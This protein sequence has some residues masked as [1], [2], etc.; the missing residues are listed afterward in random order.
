MNAEFGGPKSIY[1]PP[2]YSSPT[3]YKMCLRLFLNGDSNTRGTHMSL[4]LVILRG[5]YD[6]IVHWPFNFKIK[7][8]LLNQFQSDNNQSNFFW[9]DP[10]SICFQRPNT[11][12]N[13]PY[14]ISKFFPLNVLKQNENHYVRDNTMLVTVELDFLAKIPGRIALLN[15]ILIIFCLEMLSN[16]AASELMND[17]EYNNITDDDISVMTCRSDNFNDAQ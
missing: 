15:N 11:N 9:S 16:G 17:G 7:F 5:N 14:G 1:S 3:G 13:I 10:T 6:P 8:T 4:Y 2:F 12:M